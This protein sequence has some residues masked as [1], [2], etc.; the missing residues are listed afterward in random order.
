M[1]LNILYVV[2]SWFVLHYHLRGQ[3][4][5][6]KSKG[7]DVEVACEPDSRAT[8]A[9]LIEGVKCHNII[10]PQEI[11]PIQDI[12]ALYNLIKLFKIKK[13]DVVNCCTKKGGLLGSLA[14]KHAGSQSV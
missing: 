8:K 6:L 2:P 11:N 5:F 14:A 13:Y 9:A 4:S 3:L 7:F 12:I 1:S 10:I